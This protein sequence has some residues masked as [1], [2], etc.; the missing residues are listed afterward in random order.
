MAPSELTKLC[1]DINYLSLAFDVIINVNFY[2]QS[3]QQH[4]TF[5]VRFLLSPS[6][7]QTGD[8]NEKQRAIS[9]MP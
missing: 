8:I 3:P 2:F 7:H 6:R 4:L 1:Y 5:V 9:R